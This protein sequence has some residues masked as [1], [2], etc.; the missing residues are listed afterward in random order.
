MRLHIENIAKFEMADIDIDGITVIAGSNNTGKST[1]GK[2]L[3]TMVDSFYNIDKFVRD[4]KPQDAKKL[5]NKQGSNLDLI[6]KKLSGL[7]RRKVA[8]VEQLQG[9]YAFSLAGAQ[10]EDEISECV[11]QYCKEH[12]ELYGVMDEFPNDEVQYWIKEACNEIIPSMMD[13]DS[14]YAKIYGMQKSFEN[15]F[16]SQICKGEKQG[17]QTLSPK[18]S[19]VAVE[20]KN[21]E[22]RDFV[23]RNSVV[24]ENNT[25]KGIHQEFTVDARALYIENPRILDQFASLGY[26][27]SEAEAKKIIADWLRPGEM[28]GRI[29]RR[30]FNWGIIQRQ[31]PEDAMEDTEINAEMQHMDEVISEINSELINLMDGTIEFADTNRV[32]DFNDNNYK[33][34]FRLMNLSTGLKAVSLLQCILHYRALTPDTILILDEPEINLHP[35]WQVKYAEYIAILQSRLNLNIVVTT[36]SP[37][38]LKALENASVKNR[39]EDKCH[40][41]YA[42]D[43]NGDAYLDC[44]DNNIQEIYSKMMMPLFTMIEDMGL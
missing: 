21:K 32:L 35:E 4:W 42:Y 22:A 43:K 41:Y 2:A 11:R 36:H 39:I 3:F 26:E 34:N 44:A 7:K 20:V 31:K 27:S 24:L 28:N 10:G 9:R 40:Y 19:R 25:V 13:Y 17:E 15:I 33:G 38:F 14:E 18:K 16:G 5:L 29:R 23:K 12:L 37:F 30:T 8:Y 6:C 1:I